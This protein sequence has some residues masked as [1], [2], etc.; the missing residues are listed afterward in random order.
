MPVSFVVGLLIN[1]AISVALSLVVSLLTPRAQQQRQTNEPTPPNGSY[2]ERQP[3]PPLRV[4]FG[5]VK[6]GGDLAFLEE[7][8]G[9][10][11]QIIVH[12]A[13]RIEGYVQ[14]WLHDE[15][16][17]LD[18]SHNSTAPAHFNG[19]VRIE[20]SLG[21]DAETAWPLAVSIFPSIWTTDHRGDGLAKAMLRFGN[22]D[23]QSFS[24]VYP[25]GMPVHT[26]VIDGAH[27]FDPRGNQDPNDPSTWAFS[28]NLALGRLFHLT[29]PSG[30]RLKINDLYLPEWIVAAD[31]ADEIVINRDGQEE[32]RYWGGISWKYRGDGQDAVSVGQKFDEAAELV[33]YQRGDGLIGVHAGTIGEPDI[34]LDDDDFLS[35]RYDAN[36]SQANTVLAVRGHWTDPRNQWAKGDAAIWGDPY[37]ADDET[38]RT[39]TV[40]NEIVQSH[41]HIQRLQKIKMI[42]ANAPRVSATIQYD[43]AKADIM[44]RRFIKVTK[45]N[46]GLDGA[47]LELVGGTKLSLEDLTISFDAIVVPANL[48]SFDG[49]TEEGIPGAVVGL[50]ESTGVPEPTGFAVA[51]QS[52]TLSSGA[53]ATY[54]QAS[55][56]FV[57][58]SLTYELQFQ[59]LDESRPPQSVGSNPGD[60][61]VRTPAL[62]AGTVYRL[63]L[64]TWSAGAPSPWTDYLDSDGSDPTPPDAPTGLS[65]ADGAPGLI[66][67]W[68]NPS[69]A[70][71]DHVVLY[72]AV[73]TSFADATVEYT[74]RSGASASPSWHA[75]WPDLSTGTYSVWVRAFNTVGAA[76]ALVGP[77]SIGPI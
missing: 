60:T 73:G 28:R 27:V 45:P 17:T 5:R 64:R 8:G 37:T 75:T 68:T 53:T 52:E 54:V 74:D 66:A 32:P 22:V 30:G 56:D 46:R 31:R 70:N 72:V 9:V 19:N 59:V 44:F 24:T 71:L 23:S 11:Y 57:D 13:H 15:I 77:Q 20:E 29:H 47:I 10:A 55:W 1:L 21:L 18:G 49:P 34:V 12:F 58:A 36:Q 39:G 40:D 35:F 16:V 50:V 25:Q 2:N 43:D 65:V 48:Y 26:A 3:I 67:S 42:R 76:S 38:Q 4:G 51:L 63:R 33:V 69:S 61:T 41:N 6:T 14:H 7:K 62:E